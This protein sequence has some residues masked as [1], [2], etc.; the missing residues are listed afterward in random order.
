MTSLPP[1]AEPPNPAP[2]F[3][4]GDLVAWRSGDGSQME[5]FVDWIHTD[6]DGQVWAFVSLPGK[7]WSAVNVKFLKEV[8]S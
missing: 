2:T 4:P 3:R 8:N 5:G 7:S 1:R 6:S